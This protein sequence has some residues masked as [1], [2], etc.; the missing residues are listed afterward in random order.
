METLV[1]ECG[2][3]LQVGFLWNRR[4]WI[5]FHYTLQYV[6]ARFAIGVDKGFTCHDLTIRIAVDYPN[7]FPP[8]RT[9]YLRAVCSNNELNFWEGVLQLLQ[10]CLLPSRVQMHI[11]LVDKHNA[12]GFL[13]GVFFVMVIQQRTAAGKITDQFNHAANTIAQ[14]R[15]LQLL[16][17]MLEKQ[18]FFARPRELNL[19]ARDGADRI[20]HPLP[21]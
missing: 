2:E 17:A 20:A 15:E 14:L 5:H 6:T 4:Q 11:D 13:H 9:Q 1:N 16:G 21:Q 19:P 7:V 12:R 8:H 3:A 18:I 10:N